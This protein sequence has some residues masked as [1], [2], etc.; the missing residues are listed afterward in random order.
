MATTPSRIGGPTIGSSQPAWMSSIVRTSRAFGARV[1]S[2]RY[3][4][5]LGVAAGEGGRLV[6]PAVRV[7]D[8]LVVHRAA[9]RD[10][11]GVLDRARDLGLGQAEVRARG[12]DHVL[13]D[14][15]AAEVVRAE[16]QRQLPDLRALGDP[17]GLHAR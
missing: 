5:R 15:Q 1:A 4:R 12:R 9:L 8:D 10:E 11:A 2:T 16:A 3:R 13:F 17:G 6:A 14:H 7:A